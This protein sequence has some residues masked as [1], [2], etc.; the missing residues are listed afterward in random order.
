[1]RHAVN[2]LGRVLLA[3]MFVS[4]G[5]GKLTA[6][7]ATSHYLQSLDIP[8]ALLPVVILVELGGG[9]A[10]LLGLFTRVAAVGLAVFCVLT[11]VMV[12]Y[13]LAHA[14]TD[15]QIQHLQMLNVMKNL[16]IAGGF[17]VLA[18]HGAGKISLDQRLRSN[19]E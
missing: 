3:Y 15:V 1:M 19:A 5:W 8:T 18:A 9:I 12:H 4:S 7:A 11:A 10:I 2:L 6:Y 13:P 16:A 17:L 14:A